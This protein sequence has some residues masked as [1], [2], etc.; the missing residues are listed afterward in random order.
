M[1]AQNNILPAILFVPVLGISCYMDNNFVD[2]FIPPKQFYL[3]FTSGIFIIGL[4]LRRLFKKGEL[5]IKFDVIDLSVLL[6]FVYSLFNLLDRRGSLHD[7]QFTILTIL[8]FLFFILRKTYTVGDNDKPIKIILL[9][10]MGFT[11]IQVVIGLLQM[12]GFITNGIPNFKVA[13]SFGN[14]GPYTNYLVSVLPISIIIGWLYKP[15]NKMDF[16]LQKIAYWLSVAIIVVLP[17][18]HARTSWVTAV[19]CLAII[20]LTSIHLK[21]WYK[22]LT[23]NFL[24]RFMLIIAVSLFTGITAYYL[25]AFKKDSARGRLF[26][27][28]LTTQ[29]IKDHPLTGTGFNTFALAH[30]DYQ[31][32]YFANSTERNRNRILAD[33]ITYAFNEYL[34]LTSELGIIGF[35]LFLFILGAA[36]YYSPKIKDM[37]LI[38]RSFFISLFPILICALFSYPFH[39]VPAFLNFFI[40]L[41]FIPTVKNKHTITVKISP[42]IYKFLALFL[43]ILALIFLNKKLQVYKAN[44]QWKA[45]AGIIRSGNTDAAFRKYQKVY[46][47]LRRDGLFLYNYGSELALARQ[48]SLSLQ[49]L[50]EALDRIND[51]DVYNYLGESYE[52]INDL[53]SAEESFLHAYHIIPHKI[54]PLYRLVY[55]YAKQNEPDKAMNLAKKV[56]NMDV[57]VKSDV[58][59]RI[60]YD[61]NELIKQFEQSKP[62][63]IA[64]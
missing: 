12:Y 16:F 46:P 55:L 29:I 19:I 11:A 9:A 40:F 30:N 6:Y 1:K 58:T 8:L 62:D 41:S 27:W 43:I 31:A 60:K 20:L 14:P 33:N 28:H 64:N 50:H 44:K 24:A 15:G 34:Q 37:S 32:N 7:S 21:D 13:G 18:T 5:H 25:Y 39:D 45:A 36:F 54:Y 63:S 47:V 26:T 2:K 48:Y 57:K 4:L 10:L 59:D 3:F 23:S 17:S 49:I 53:K 22:K 61:L 56:A 35:I 51:A 52:G 38:Q 42:G